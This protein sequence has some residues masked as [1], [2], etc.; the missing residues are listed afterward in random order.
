MRKASTPGKVFKMARTKKHKLRSDWDVYRIEVMRKAVYEKFTQNEDLKE[1][2]LATGDRE[3][4]EHTKNDNFWG[5]GGNGTGKN[6][7][8]TILKEVR[9]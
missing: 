3:L 6:M 4:I 2:L 5:D 9:K 7:L 1:K 8:G